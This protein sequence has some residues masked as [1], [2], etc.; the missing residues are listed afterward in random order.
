MLPAG[1]IGD[2]VEIFVP[3]SGF[4]CEVLPADGSTSID[5]SGAGNGI[6]VS[7]GRGVF[8]RKLTS[9][10]WRGIGFDS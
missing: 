5:D 6:S 9:T 1:E 7:H 2:V 4:S 10:S 3:D 8:L